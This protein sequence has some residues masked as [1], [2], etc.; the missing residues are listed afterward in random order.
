MCR[1]AYANIENVN[2]RYDAI[3]SIAVNSWNLGNRDGVG[4]YSWDDTGDMLIKGLKWDAFNKDLLNVADSL[5]RNTIIHAR[6]STNEITELNTQPLDINGVV[7]AHNG[8]I[9]SCKYK[10]ETTTNDSEIIIQAYLK[11]DTDID[12]LNKELF[13]T[14]NY[15]LYDKSTDKLVFNADSSGMSVVST[16]G[17][18]FVVQQPEQLKGVIKTGLFNPIGFEKVK[19]GHYLITTSKSVFKPFIKKVAQADKVYRRYSYPI[20]MRDREWEKEIIEGELA[21]N[22]RF[23]M[24]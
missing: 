24:E 19:S 2:E 23:W 1:I 7:V 12:A 11:V 13:G 3:A 10:P 18:F 9:N 21:V 4:I 22:R 8:H 17:N 15:I 6:L 16:N 14:Y 5:K 20:G